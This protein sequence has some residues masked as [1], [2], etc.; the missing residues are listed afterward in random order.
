MLEPSFV[1]R[2]DED[3]NVIPKEIKEESRFGY[4][5]AKLKKGKEKKCK[6]DCERIAPKGAVYGNITI[7]SK[8]ICFSPL[9]GERPDQ[10]QY[11]FGALV[12]KFFSLFA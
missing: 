4:L 1:K 7:I 3:I 6:W 9:E 11:N 5:R 10:P 8:Y 12:N 2:T